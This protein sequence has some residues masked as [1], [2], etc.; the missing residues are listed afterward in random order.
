MGCC[1]CPAN[2]VQTGYVVEKRAVTVCYQCWL[3]PET[4][5]STMPHLSVPGVKAIALLR[6]ELPPQPLITSPK[7][8]LSWK[9]LET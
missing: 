3:F 1:V 5:G 6:A 4:L 8:P 7:P 9:A 2:T